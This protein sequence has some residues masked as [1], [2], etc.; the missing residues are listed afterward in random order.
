MMKEHISIPV[1]A[2]A[3]LTLLAAT[4]TPA[5]ALPPPLGSGPIVSQAE[6]R[7]LMEIERYAC[8]ILDRD[9]IMLEEKAGGWWEGWAPV[10]V[11]TNW[12]VVL[13][14]I[15][16]PYLPDITTGYPFDC[17]IEGDPKGWDGDSVSCMLVSPIVCGYHTRLYAGVYNPNLLVR[18][19]MD[20]PQQVATVYLTLQQ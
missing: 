17:L 9:F 16:E 4:V 2:A 11:K 15:I 3:I 20:K 12:N 18:A 14:A 1:V 6:V 13:T 8:I 10:T 19:S 5:A 7:V